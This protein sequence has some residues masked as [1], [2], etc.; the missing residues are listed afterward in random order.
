[1]TLYHVH[2][3]REMRLY[4][5]DIEA[6]TPEAAARLADARPTGEAE[7]IEDCEGQSLSALVDVAS[8]DDFSRSVVIDFAPE[9][10]RK[11]ADELVAALDYLLQQTVDMDLKYGIGLTEGEEE[12]RARALAVIARAAEDFIISN[13]TT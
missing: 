10:R 3:Y 8:D 11:L 1:M 5:P 12:A 9:R 13:P 4:F 6:A 2:I 7:Y